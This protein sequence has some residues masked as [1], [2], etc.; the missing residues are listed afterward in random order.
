MNSLTPAASP[1]GMSHADAMLS[2]DPDTACLGRMAASVAMVNIT[3][4]LNDELQRGTHP[5]T[6]LLSLA[7]LQ[8]MTHASFAAQILAQPAMPHCAEIYRAVIED[9]EEHAAR[10]QRAVAPLREAST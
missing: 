2:S 6:I 9:Y 1:E 10:T 3:A 8:M 4:L 7:R 5:A